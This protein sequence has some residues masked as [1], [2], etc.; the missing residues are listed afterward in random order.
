[1]VV[2][3]NILLSLYYVIIVLS[4]SFLLQSNI[5]P[6]KKNKKVSKERRYLLEKIQHR[7]NVFSIYKFFRQLAMANIWRL[8]TNFEPSNSSHH[9]AY[10]YDRKGFLLKYNFKHFQDSFSKLTFVSFS[11]LNVILNFQHS[12]L[13]NKKTCWISYFLSKSTT[14]NQKTLSQT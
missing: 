12:G 14:P 11:N 9:Q 6:Q 2:I 8:K 7:Y 3:I 1:M 13:R 10:K 5:V 4:L